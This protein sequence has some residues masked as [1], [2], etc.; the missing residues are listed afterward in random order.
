LERGHCLKKYQPLNGNRLPAQ[1]RNL[2][3]GVF[4]NST[5]LGAGQVISSLFAGFFTASLTHPAWNPA[6]NRT[7]NYH[8]GHPQKTM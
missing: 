7:I 2:L 1:V 8:I 6:G 3:C 4:H 5:L